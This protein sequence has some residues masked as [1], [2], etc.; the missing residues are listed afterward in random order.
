MYYRLS[1]KSEAEAT[2]IVYEKVKV[3]NDKKLL[4]RN[5]LDV[6][7]KREGRNSIFPCGRSYGPDA[8]DLGQLKWAADNGHFWFLGP[9]KGLRVK[10]Q[11]RTRVNNKN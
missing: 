11:V 9:I 5:P 6:E 10:Q 8:L 7:I 4:S 1:G 3:L 2:K